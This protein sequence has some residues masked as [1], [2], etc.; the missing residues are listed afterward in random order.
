MI[1]ALALLLIATPVGA[2]EFS[3]TPICTLSHEEAETQISVTYDHA[4]ALYAIALTTP[5]GWPDSPVFSIRFDGPRSNVISTPRHNVSGDTLT[6]RDTGFGNV[7]DGLE[8]N[9][10]A[11]AFTD[12]A[13][14]SVS[15][16]GAGEPVQAFR[17]CTKSP[18]V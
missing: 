6:V 16:E 10:S 13:A 5:D 7:L 14:R 3:A 8:F 1:R 4:T 17:A 15:L 9:Q 11:T 18:S 12:T 2:W